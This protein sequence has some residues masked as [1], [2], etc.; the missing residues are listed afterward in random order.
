MEIAG[1]VGQGAVGRSLAQRLLAEDVGR[2]HG[3]AWADG[4]VVLGADVPWVRG[5]TWIGQEPQAA[6][7]YLPTR[8]ASSVDPRWLIEALRSQGR[9]APLLVLPETGLLLSLAG[10]RPLHGEALR[11]W[12]TA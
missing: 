9:R 11:A 1:A 12:M 5:L 8:V 7:L 2:W 3:V 4:L 6:A 10:A